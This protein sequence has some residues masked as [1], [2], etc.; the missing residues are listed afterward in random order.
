VWTL[1]DGDA[2]VAQD[3]PWGTSRCRPMTVSLVRV[4]TDVAEAF[5]QVRRELATH[6][7]RVDVAQTDTLPPDL[8]AATSTPTTWVDAVDRFHD[9]PDQLYRLRMTSAPFGQGTTRL[10]SARVTVAHDTAHEAPAGEPD[11]LLRRVARNAIAHGHGIG[12]NRDPSSAL[13]QDQRRA[14]DAW[15]ERDVADLR[16]QDGCGRSPDA[17][18]GGAATAEGTG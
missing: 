11:A 13:Y 7:V 9:G 15:S 4:P 8:T 12:T 3:R 14:P 1:I 16:Q 5:Q 6:G 17:A 10:T 18:T 2:V